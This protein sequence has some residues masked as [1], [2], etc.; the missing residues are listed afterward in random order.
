MQLKELT[1]IVTLADEKTISGAAEKLYMAQS[2]LSEF[3]QQQEAE[4]GVKLFI[5]SSRGLRPTEAGYEYIQTARSLLQ[6]YHQTQAHLRDIAGLRRGSVVLGISSF[7]G[8]YMVPKLLKEFRIQYPEIRVKI[9]EGNSIAI[10]SMLI[11]GSIDMGVVALP[12]TKLKQDVE[13]LTRDEVFL[14]VNKNHPIMQYVHPIY[15]NEEEYEEFKKTLTAHD[16]EEARYWVDL[17]DTE[18]YEYILSDVDTILGNFARQQFR[19]HGINPPTYNTTITAD[20]AAVMGRA[21]LG[22]AFTYH[23]CAV[24]IP[25]AVYLRIGPE[26]LF[27]D[28]GLAYPMATYQSHASRAL[29]RVA[30]QTLSKI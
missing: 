10:E 24:P 26:G 3:L 27:V 21:G 20:L 16:R 14:A 13:A 12:L 7:R 6:Q 8:R 29:A 30:H 18:P 23:S 28:L 15:D 4:L 1:Y 5:R 19:K 2:S 11:E 9:K 25:D 17:K 22:L